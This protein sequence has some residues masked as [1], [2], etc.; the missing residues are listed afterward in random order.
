MQGWQIYQI[1][2]V[3]EAAKVRSSR[4]TY[5]T[6]AI[7]LVSGELVNGT[8]VTATMTE[9]LTNLGIRAWATLSNLLVINAIVAKIE[10]CPAEVAQLVFR[11]LGLW[12]MPL[13]DAAFNSMTVSS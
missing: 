9:L 8:V 12:A 4:Q 13:A 10:H 5:R 11:V 7:A 6:V 1:D 2:Q 3:L